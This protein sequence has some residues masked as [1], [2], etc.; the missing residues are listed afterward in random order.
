MPV[1]LF[2]NH[3]W[4]LSKQLEAALKKYPD[5]LDIILSQPNRGFFR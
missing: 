1:C 4:L 5:A 3:V 2:T